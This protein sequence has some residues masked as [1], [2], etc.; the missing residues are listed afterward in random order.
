M[1]IF[2][3]LMHQ[4]IIQCWPYSLYN[5]IFHYLWFI[6]GTDSFYFMKQSIFGKWSFWTRSI[7]DKMNPNKLMQIFAFNACLGSRGMRRGHGGRV[8][9]VG[10][11]NWFFPHCTALTIIPFPPSLKR[12]SALPEWPPSLRWGRKILNGL[13]HRNRL[14]NFCWSLIV[15]VVK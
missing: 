8:S 11:Q 13:R 5:F 15:K 6:S 12:V 4:F 3:N 7:L 1:N 9:D 14:R 10:A 2:I